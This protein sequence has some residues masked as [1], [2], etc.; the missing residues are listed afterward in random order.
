MERVQHP[1]TR[2]AAS[3]L[4]DLIAPLVR[5]D[6]YADTSLDGVRLMASHR[7]IPRTPLLYEPSI[8]VV[9]QGG[10]LGYLGERT[11]RYGPGTYLVQ[12]LPLPFECETRASSDAPLLGVSVRIDPAMLNELASAGGPVDESQDQAMLS[13]MAAVTMSEEMHGAVAR[14]LR[15]LHDPVEA[16]A[17]GE[18]RIRDVIFAALQGAQGPALRALV[19]GEGNYARIVQALSFMHEAYNRD[20]SVEALAGRAYMSVSSFHHH[21]RAVAGTTPLQYLKKLRLIKA[22]LLLC[23]DGQTVHRAAGAVGYRSVPQ[24]SR[25]YKRTFGMPPSRE[26]QEPEIVEA[27]S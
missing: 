9:A 21:F 19:F 26:R 1:R 6:G 7:P 14:L 18:A 12:T 10:K 11:I 23:Q 24:F 5:A 15:A 25:D 20:L 8:I 4:A 17:M 13:P 2:P 3:D 16:R 22:R 27:A